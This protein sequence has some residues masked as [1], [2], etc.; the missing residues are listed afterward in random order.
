MPLDLLVS[1]LLLPADAPSTLRAARLPSLEK[2][3]ARADLVS[4]AGRDSM[5]WLASAYG[6]AL[7]PSV[8]AIALAGEGAPQDGTWMR[9]DPVHLRIDH[10]YLKL[11]DASILEVTREES[12]LLVAA[13]QSHFGADGLEFRAAAADR[14]YVRLPEAEMPHTTPL[15]H[16]LGRDVFGLLPNQ[17]AGAGRRINWRSALTEAQMVLAAHEVNAARE[18]A[19]KLAINSVWFWGEGSAAGK[20]ARPYEIVYADEAFARGLGVLSGADVRPLPKSIAAV[21][22][23]REGESVL[24]VIGGLTP[25]LRRADA[26]AWQATADTLDAGW[27]AALGEAIDRF[28]RVRIILPAE[29]DTRVATLTAASR[30]RWFRTRKPLAAHA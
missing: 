19:G 15:E 1:D 23:V 9:A 24:A 11:H 17:R 13:L 6:L 29:K 14:W 21:D 4:M 5:Q 8:A 18:A 2:W 27:F 26:K 28:G 7:P 3:L 12:E 30:W 25:A 16:A 20:L 22:L 10:D